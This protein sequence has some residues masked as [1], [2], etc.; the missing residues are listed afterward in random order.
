MF[1]HHSYVS[2]HWLVAESYSQQNDCN[3]VDRIDVNGAD[4]WMRTRSHECHWLSHCA[5]GSRILR[6]YARFMMGII[7]S[8]S[9]NGCKQF[10]GT[11]KWDYPLFWVVGGQWGVRAHTKPMLLVYLLKWCRGNYLINFEAKAISSKPIYAH[12][13]IFRMHSLYPIW[14]CAST[15]THV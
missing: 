4:G 1:I 2:N 11:S 14:K 5:C 15:A 13:G 10:S 6:M 8:L 12:S 7:F 3:I 9:P